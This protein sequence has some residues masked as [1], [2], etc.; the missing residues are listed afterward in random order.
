MTTQIKLRR[1]TAANWTSANPVLALGEFGFETDTKRFKL[2]DGSTAYNSLAYTLGPEL[3]S[4]E[5]LTSAADK[6]PYFTGAGTASTMTVTSA[7]RDLLDDTTAGAMLTTLG[8]QPLDSDLTAIAALTTTAYG[9]SQLGLADVASDTAQLNVMTGGGGT[10]LKGLV[11]AQV[12][13]DVTKFLRGD[14]TWATVAAGGS[15]FFDDDGSTP[16]VAPS[17][18]GTDAIAI[19]DGAI[20][21]STNCQAWGTAAEADSTHA[22]AIGANANAGQTAGAQSICIGSD[23]SSTDNSRATGAQSIAIGSSGLSTGDGARATGQNSIAIGGG[24]STFVGPLASATSTIAMGL[25]AAASATNAIAIAES[26]AASQSNAIAI[27]NAAVASGA[28]SLALGNSSTAS[29]ANAIAIGQNT[30]ATA[31]NSIAIGGD[32][33]DGN[34]ADASAI[35]SIALGINAKADRVGE[36]ALAT[37]AASSTGGRASIFRWAGNTINATPAEIFLMKNGSSRMTIPSDC[38]TGFTIY[39]TARRT[40]SDNESAY[41]RIDGCIDNNGGTTAAVGSITTTVIAEDTAGWDVAATADDTNDS[42]KITVTGSSAAIQWNA[43]G[44]II[45][46]RG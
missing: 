1:D 20:A 13:G 37:E 26:A 30:D 21:S 35:N 12:A 31:A 27:G 41:Y 6:V 15:A 10:G 19:G 7:A 18:T 17:A 39:V 24:Q 43:M 4:I 45:E 40:D 33:T 36:F 22:I 32:G 29:A 23:D 44:F 14:A 34:S 2:G 3:S 38:T 16:G 46:S 25:S 42:L 28:P 11:P 9:R 8:A 5:G